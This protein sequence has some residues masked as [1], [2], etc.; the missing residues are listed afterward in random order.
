MQ[1]RPLEE[2]LASHETSAERHEQTIARLAAIAEDHDQLLDRLVAN[3]EAIANLLEEVTRDAATTRRLW[4]RLAQ[5]YGWMDDEQNGAQS[6][7]P[8]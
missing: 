5:R 6:E 4:L 3:Q 8:A 2:R 7:T 1:E